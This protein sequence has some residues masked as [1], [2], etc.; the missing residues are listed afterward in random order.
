MKRFEDYKQEVILAYE[1]KKKEGTLPPKLESYTTAN[2]KAECLNVFHN[3]YSDKD[4]ETFKSLFGERDSAEEYAKRIKAVGADK[5]KPLYNFLKGEIKAP[6]NISIEL[7]AWF[8]DF[9]PRP[10]KPGD[11]YDLVKSEWDSPTAKKDSVREIAND[12][13]EET[14]TREPNE[15]ETIDKPIEPEII[16]EKFQKPTTTP[17]YDIGKV[18]DSK[19]GIPRKFNKTIFAFLAAFITLA[20]SYIFYDISKYRCMYWDNDHYESVAC[21]QEVEGEIIV[22][23]NK[24]SLEHLKRITNWATISRDDIGKVHYSKLNNKVE[25]YTTSGENPADNRKRLL[26]MTEYMYEKYVLNKPLP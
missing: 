18:N 22:P 13:R 17:L 2:L 6:K 19:F 4:S 8:I 16:E 3:R 10:Y 15:T 24:Y 7:L 23:L 14:E 11:I 1:K 20:G 26:P 25:F 21:D 5:F 9:E 12:H